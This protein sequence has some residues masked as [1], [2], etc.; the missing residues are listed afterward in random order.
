MARIS[1]SAKIAILR[2]LATTKVLPGKFSN[3]MLSISDLNIFNKMSIDASSTSS[4]LPITWQAEELSSTKEPKSFKDLSKALRSSE[5]SLKILFAKDLLKLIES[6]STPKKELFAED[7]TKGMQKGMA[8]DIKA[9]NNEVKDQNDLKKEI[10]KALG[11]K[12]TKSDISK[13]MKQEFSAIEK[14][15]MDFSSKLPQ[16]E[17]TLKKLISLMQREVKSLSSDL[18]EM[19]KVRLQLLHAELIKTKAQLSNEN[20]NIH[21]SI[22]KDQTNNAKSKADTL[23]KMPN[24]LI[25]EKDT[26][27][28]EN[29]SLSHTSLH[30]TQQTF[31]VLITL[32]HSL[33]ELRRALLDAE[34]GAIATESSQ[35]SLQARALIPQGIVYPF[36]SFKQSVLASKAKKKKMEEFSEE[37]EGEEEDYPNKQKKQ[38]H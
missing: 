29:K 26:K 21:P 12:M 25:K 6:L 17:K 32:Y 23:S 31:S 33:L 20:I 34:N 10:S 3:K 15:L 13:S 8:G 38:S 22:S 30:R 28:I 2:A 18:K 9:F 11:S 7:M 4:N 35:G 27:S 16:S 14:K 5:F 19:P 36:L 37:E 1:I 24:D